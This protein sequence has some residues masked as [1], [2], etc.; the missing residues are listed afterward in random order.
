MI[1]LFTSI[2]TI[3][4]SLF[5]KKYTRK[6]SKLSKWKVLKI[7]IKTV[8]KI[9]LFIVTFSPCILLSGL[10]YGIANDYNRIYE[11][12]FYEII[13]NNIVV[14]DFEFGFTILIK[15]CAKIVEEPWFMFFVVSAITVFLFVKSFE[16]SDSFIISIIL[17]FAQGIY[18][19]SFNGIRQYIV[20]AI[21]LYAYRYIEE[22]NLKNYI[23]TMSFA[24]L[25]HISA[26]ITLPLYFLK[27]V[28]L[29]YAFFLGSALCLF[30][31]KIKVYE[32]FLR[33]MTLLPKSNSYIAKGTYA[34]YVSTNVSGLLISILVL[35]LFYYVYSKMAGEETG[36]FQLN[37]A[38]LGLMFA[39]CST[40]LP[41][42]DRFLYF[43]KS[44]YLL[45]V[46]YALSLISSKKERTIV[47][48]VFV[49][50]ILILNIYGI[51]FNDWYGILPYRSIFS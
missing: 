11:R 1:Y 9:L 13:S 23:I 6:E 29:N 15:L 5:Y 16:K 17:F 22:D 14:T 10:R 35:I 7:K 4:A 42:M 34:N 3:I 40:F 19:D 26:L 50:F 46:P 30:L 24:S 47:T 49:V 44:Y 32:I 41:L 18:F 28:K 31:F 38:F 39:I 20:V 12:G 36:V 37:M 48:V 21:F 25:F 27:K 45:S 43:T 2:Y 33:L 8:K 51:V